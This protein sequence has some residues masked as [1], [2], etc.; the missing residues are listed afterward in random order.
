[1]KAKILTVGG[2]LYKERKKEG[3]R[4]KSS[5]WYWIRI[6]GIHIDSW[7]LIYNSDTHTHI[8]IYIHT[9]THI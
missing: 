9:H 7:F 8:Y 2:R 6:G 3:R 1:M 5:L 4:I